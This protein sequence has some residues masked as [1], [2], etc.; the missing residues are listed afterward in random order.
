MEWVT[1]LDKALNEDRLVL[2]CQRIVPVTRGK[3]ATDEHYEILLTMRDE[4]GETMPPTDFIIAAET[5]NRMTAIDRWV[6]ERVLNWMSI[7][8]FAPVPYEALEFYAQ[9]P[10]AQKQITLNRYPVFASIF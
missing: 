9:E 2:N 7:S 10:L 3:G 8:F 1:E 4:L 6:I 5:Y